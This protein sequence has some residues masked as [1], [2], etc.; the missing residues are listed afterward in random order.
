MP[1]RREISFYDSIVE[2]VT[3]I[4]C[5]ERMIAPKTLK[6]HHVFCSACIGRSIGKNKKIRCPT[7]RKN[8]KVK[9][10]DP[11]SLPTAFMVNRIADILDRYQITSQKYSSDIV[12]GLGNH[13]N[14]T[15]TVVLKDSSNVHDY[16]DNEPKHGSQAT[17]KV[18]K[19][20]DDALLKQ[21]N[22][23]RT[24]LPAGGSV[25]MDESRGGDNKLRRNTHPIVADQLAVSAPANLVCASTMHK[26]GVKF[27]VI[28]EK[29]PNCSED[30]HS[31]HIELIKIDFVVDEK[32]EIVVRKRC[33]ASNQC[34]LLPGS[35]NAVLSDSSGN[36]LTFNVL[37]LPDHCWKLSCK[38]FC[39]GK[40]AAVIKVDERLIFASDLYVSSHF[41]APIEV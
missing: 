21:F 22:L 17:A 20:K 16:L 32:V 10:G 39:E 33:K 4:V 40:F 19:L 41:T 5:F 1:D 8:T 23:R 28:L 6:C 31:Y 35:L 11:V 14:P 7:C 25:P 37:S 15:S 30:D 24:S 2:E 36:N 34:S 12:Y 27:D 29:T 26:K 13:K 18:A 38:P 9:N 3:C